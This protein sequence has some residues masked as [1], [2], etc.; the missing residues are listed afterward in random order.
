[1]SLFNFIKNLNKKRKNLR[2]ENKEILKRKSIIE[3]VKNNSV[4]TNYSTFYDTNNILS[5]LCEKH[6]TDKGYVEFEKETP[7]G[8]RPHSYSIYYNALFS[9]CRKDIKLILECGIGSNNLDVE[10]NMTTKGK[11]GASLRVWKEY[12]DNA[13]IIG[14]DIDKRILF[15]EDR[16][17]TYEVNQ[18][19]PTS[20]K[21]M[22]SKIKH[23]NFDIII[24]DGLHTLEAGLTFFLNSFEKLKEGGIY[25]IEDVDFSYLN[26]LKDKLIKYNPEVVILNNNYSNKSSFRHKNLNDNNLIV[27]RKL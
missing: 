2:K 27:V 3:S 8:W 21:N 4:G 20:I 16:I 17:S 5:K 13:Q 19:N 25:I 22:W 1:M 12:F 26:E 15:Q 11:P 18:L 23:N 7:Y 9:H 6:G 10:S 14:A 24:D